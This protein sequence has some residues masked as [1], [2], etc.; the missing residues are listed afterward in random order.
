MDSEEQHKVGGIGRLYGLFESTGTRRKEQHYRE[1][2]SWMIPVASNLFQE[3]SGGISRKSKITLDVQGNNTVYRAN[4][5]HRR[6][7]HVTRG[8]QEVGAGISNQNSPDSYW[9][10]AKRA[11]A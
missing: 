4:Y 8:S 9:R 5:E 10:D 6:E 1:T 2:C 3:Q 11:T 7:I